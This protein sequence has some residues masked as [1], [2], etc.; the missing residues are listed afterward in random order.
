MAVRGRAFLSEHAED[1]RS[2]YNKGGLAQRVRP[3]VAGAMTGSGV[4][5]RLALIEWRITLR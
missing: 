2:R 3:E 1:N 5:R 4:I